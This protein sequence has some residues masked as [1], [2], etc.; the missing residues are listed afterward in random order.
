MQ[1]EVFYKNRISFGRESKYL[2]IYRGLKLAN[3]LLT[4]VE[5]RYCT[6]VEPKN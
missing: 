4:L 6:D 5:D 1:L 2:Q 3:L